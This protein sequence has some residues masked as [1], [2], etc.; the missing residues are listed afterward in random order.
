MV[1]LLLFAAVYG[2]WL[3]ICYT[4]NGFWAYP[5][6][7]ILSNYQRLMLY[8]ASG[9]TACGFYMLGRLPHKKTNLNITLTHQQVPKSM[10]V[11]MVYLITKVDLF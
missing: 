8:T 10:P 6:F 9:L 5:F 11:F 2:V 4:M 1:R 3:Q 7:A